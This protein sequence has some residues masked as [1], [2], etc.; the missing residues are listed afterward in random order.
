[1]KNNIAQV[2]LISF[3]LAL[4]LKYYLGAESP[5]IVTMMSAIMMSIGAICFMFIVFSNNLKLPKVV[6]VIISLL[7]F[8]SFLISI[9]SENYRIEDSFLAFIYWGFATIPLF[10]KLNYRVFLIVAYTLIVF[11]VYC[12]IQGLI[13]ETIFMV[14]RNFISV[15]LLIV[16]GY[17]Y[18]SAFQNKR[19]PSIIITILSSFISVWA[20][21]RSG[22]I[23][24]SLLLI[25]F[26]FFANLSVFKKILIIFTI[27]MV[28]VLAYNSFSNTLFEVAIYRLNA[29][30]SFQDEDRSNM[31]L[32]YVNSAINS[33]TYF[34]SGVPLKSIESMRSVDFN[35]HNSFI[36]LHIYYGIIGFLIV[37]V[38]IINSFFLFFKQKNYLYLI[39]FTALLFRSAVDS[40]AFHGPLD[41]LIFY[42]LFY[43]LTYKKTWL[44]SNKKIVA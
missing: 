44:N 6:F 1:M 10:Y 37:I 18:I 27:T 9:F 41:P 16:I 13:P 11:F 20:G 26:P 15:L 2:L 17:H 14:S 30:N 21:G 3:F 38:L 40:T 12:M 7:F 23:V 31:N 4:F 8:S 28:V 22:I 39:L 29:S 19:N 35:P 32:E 25:T 42:F 5:F 33:V 24:F 36:R 43:G 34:F